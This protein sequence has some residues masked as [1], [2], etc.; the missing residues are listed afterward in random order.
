MT[1][2]FD[3]I[4]KMIGSLV[5]RKPEEPLR[6]H[7][8]GVVSPETL[9]MLASRRSAWPCPGFLHLQGTPRFDGRL[10]DDLRQRRN[11]DKVFHLTITPPQTR[12]KPITDDMA[13]MCQDL[14]IEPSLSYEDFRKKLEKV[15]ADSMRVPAHLVPGRPWP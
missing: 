4:A 14:G 15:I 12:K 11:A 13:Q 5:G 9:E 1:S 6:F 8:G 10:E 2:L 3:G 7:T